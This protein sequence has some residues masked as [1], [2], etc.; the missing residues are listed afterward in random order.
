[1]VSLDSPI[2]FS[3]QHAY[4]S[5]EDIPA[6]LREITAEPATS[7]ASE[8]PWFGLWSALCHQGDVYP[9]SFAAVP[10]IVQVLAD[11]I[12]CACDDFFLLPASIELARS[13]RGARVPTDLADDYHQSIAR[14]P[15]L[16]GIAATRPWDTTRCRSILAAVAVAKSQ[17]ETAELLIKI[18]DGDTS[19][20]LEWYLSR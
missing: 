11:H 18:D 15:T 5:A 16:A 13:K 14:F 6:L 7:S 20:V 10:H 12:D 4:G 19:E 2:W 8:G 17:V 1:M 9:A 3:L